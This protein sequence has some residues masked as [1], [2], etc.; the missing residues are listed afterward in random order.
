VS[1]ATRPARIRAERPR[2]RT[3][4]AIAGVLLALASAA[5]SPADEASGAD[6]IVARFAAGSGEGQ[7]GLV[8]DVAD[9]APEGPAAIAA[10]PRDE[11]FVLDTLNR[12]VTKALPAPVRPTS[13]A[14]PQALH[15]VDLVVTEDFF[16][17]LDALGR[18]VLK[19]DDEGR[20]VAT[21]PVDDPAVELAGSVT[22]AV[23]PNDDLRIRR[24]GADE[25]ILGVR[26]RGEPVTAPLSVQ[27]PHGLLEST[28]QRASD[29]TAEVALTGAGRAADTPAKLAI[30]S[31]YFLASGELVRVDAEGRYYVLAEELVSAGGESVVHT[32]LARYSRAGKLEAVADVPVDAATYLPNRYLAITPRGRAYFLEPAT[33][34]T[35][36]RELPFAPREGLSLPAKAG[37]V[38]AAS[39]AAPPLVDDGF[40]A[41]VRDLYA[42][43]TT[44][45]RGAITRARI[46]ENA[47]AYLDLAWVV[48]SQNYERP[49]T[50]S[51]C[52]PPGSKWKRPTRLDGMAGRE[53]RALP[54]RWGGYESLEGFREKLGKGFLAGD[55][56]TCRSAA[57]GYCITPN[58]TGVDCSGFVSRTLEDKYYTTSTLH[59]VTDR[60]GDL[61]ELRPGDL[62]NRA[63]NHVR[64]FVGFA[65]GGP[66]ALRTIESAVSCGGVCAASYTVS[67]LARYVPLR[68][69]YVKD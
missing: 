46:L 15:A 53:V 22:L 27:T 29:A 7:I 24:H 64:L 32:V 9:R 3:A 36:V 40:E 5:P 13:F 55:V 23:L 66:L 21:V 26:S 51:R 61:R 28:F 58:A 49:G 57:D 63:G 62:L 8:V 42:E 59:R 47:R 2:P 33:G 16:Y 1:A 54:Y 19:Y 10:S 43:E 35:R 37:T 30:E 6:G 44:A 31:R 34:E 4:S 68:Y 45:T 52:D 25:V 38:P 65:E 20:L 60:L 39:R 14:T 11:L 48:G 50:A 67:Q 41:Y 17:V 12:R 18:Q 69:R 56:C